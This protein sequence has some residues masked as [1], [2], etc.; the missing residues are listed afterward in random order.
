MKSVMQHRFSEVPGV[1]LP[2]SRF[3]RSKGFKTTLDGGYL[4][5][6]MVDQEIYPGDTVRCNLTGFARLSTPTYP[7]MDNMIMDT[8]FF[9]VPHRL[10]WTNFPK[11]MGERIDPGASIAYTIPQ[12][13]DLNN[14]SNESLT[15]YFGLPTKIA[16]NIAVNSLAY[17][18]YNLIWNQWFRDENLQD[19]VVVDLDDGPDTIADYE[20]LKRGKRHDYFTSSLPWLQKGDA[21]ELSLGVDAPITG[22]GPSSQVY[23]AGPVNAYETDGTGTTA[24][25]DY[26]VISDSHADRTFYVEE[27]PNNANFP[28]IRADLANATASTV[29][30][31]RQSIQIQALLEKDARAGTRY[32]EIV[33]S[34]FGV[35]SPDARLQRP[36]YLGGGSTPIIINPVA[37]TDASP[38]VLGA[39]GTAAFNNHGFVKSF[40]EHGTI[41]GLVNVRADLTYQEG[42]E[43]QWSNQTRYDLYWPSLAHLGEQAVLNKEIYIDA[44]TVGG[45]AED[46]WGYQERWAHL[47]YGQSKITGKFR[48]NDAASLDA[49][50]LGIEFGAQPTLD[51]AFIQE[52]PPIDRVIAVPAEPHFI[53]DSYI[54]LDYVRA[55][56]TYSI[57]GFVAHF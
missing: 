28:N 52:D 49:W 48:S 34:H 4:V 57:P 55:M 32:T 3:N 10:V 12:I 30:E 37:R 54:G 33:S 38:G 2:R 14:E 29:N 26:K 41:I 7:V 36:E 8:F 35:S 15:D 20:L 9:F 21:V 24:Y 17:R 39:M 5:P 27:D 40:S 18:S 22:I 31:L 13:T 42:I 44:A 19:S 50:H 6:I 51:A 47:R 46:V 23:A 1:D 45:T 25:A 43:R 56:P 53:F 16:A 11:F